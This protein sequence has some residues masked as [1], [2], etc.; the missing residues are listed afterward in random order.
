M[1]RDVPSFHTIGILQKDRCHV[2]PGHTIVNELTDI[3]QV[4]RNITDHFSTHVNPPVHKIDERVVA[5]IIIVMVTVDYP[6]LKF[7][8]GRGRI[9]DQQEPET[10]VVKQG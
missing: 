6:S 3:L 7:F 5:E 1:E 4:N 9:M 10:T 8:R 2:S